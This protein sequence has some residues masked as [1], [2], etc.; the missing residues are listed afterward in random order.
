[1]F[2]FASF[3]PFW[4]YGGV[5]LAVSVDVKPNRKTIWEKEKERER[6]GNGP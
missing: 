4:V 6:D 1:M 3:F 5:S 2:P